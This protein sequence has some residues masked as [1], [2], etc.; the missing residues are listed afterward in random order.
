MKTI[1]IKADK[2]YIDYINRLLQDINFDDD[3]LEM[4]KLIKELNAKQDDYISLFSINIDKDYVLTID[5]AS[6][7]SNY[8]DNIVIW[9]KGK[10]ELDYKEVACLECNFEIGDITLEKEYFDFLNED[11]IIKFIF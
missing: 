4:Q 5:I 11:Y 1:E 2:K 10:T 7:T 9:K 3:S 6:G 8:Y